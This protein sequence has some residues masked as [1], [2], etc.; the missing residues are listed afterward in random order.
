[1]NMGQNKID[2]LLYHRIHNWLNYYYGK[3]DKCENIHC[4]KKTDYFTYALIKGKKYE[5]K[6]SN[7]IMLCRS[8]HAIYDLTKEGMKKKSQKMKGRKFPDKAYDTLRKRLSIKVNQYTRAGKFIASFPSSREAEK[9]TGV[10]DSSIA[11]C[12]K[13]AYKHAGGFI[14]KIA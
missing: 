3:A 6:R 4:P 10:Q 13:G 1:M 14:W 11:L 12:I 7:F 2:K 9:Q 5:K 8:C